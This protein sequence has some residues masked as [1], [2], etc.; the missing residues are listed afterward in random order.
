MTDF[1]HITSVTPKRSAIG[2]EKR[3]SGGRPG[4]GIGAR[5]A[6]QLPLPGLRVVHQLRSDDEAFW[7]T[8]ELIIDDV[9]ISWLH[10]TSYRS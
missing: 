2:L 6:S 7:L 4:L 8:M 1:R 9:Q 10:E 3:F 5:P